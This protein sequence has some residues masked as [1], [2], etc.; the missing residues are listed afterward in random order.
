MSSSK[1]TIS[2][3]FI[4]TAVFA[5]AGLVWLYYTYN[6]SGNNLFPRCPSNQFLGIICP[7]C[8]SQRAIHQLLHFNIGGAF[9]ANPLLVVSLPYIITGIAFE[10]KNV[11]N[12]YPAIRKALFGKKAIILLLIIITIY[13]LYRNLI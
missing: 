10:N 8:G 9:R 7:G 12:K 13:T 3:I 2:V 4:A 1:K 6:P 5:I 11:R